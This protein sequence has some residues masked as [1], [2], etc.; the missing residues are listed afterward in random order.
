MR[1]I[2]YKRVSSLDQNTE[3]QLIDLKPEILFDVVYEDKLSGKDTKRPQ[4][5]AMLKDLTDGDVVYV[6]RLDR[7]GRNTA[8]LLELVKQINASNATVKFVEQNLTFSPDKSNPMDQLMLTMLAA[9]SQFERELIRERQAEG[10]ALAKIKNAKL[11]EHKKLYAGRKKR[12]NDE[13]IATYIEKGYSYRKT[14]DHFGVSLST[15]QRA[16]ATVKGSEP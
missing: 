5:Q 4:L 9:F 14:A 3:K 7:L 10:I 12:V 15:V 6:H 16:V 13:A 1:S 2:A 8:D 11:P